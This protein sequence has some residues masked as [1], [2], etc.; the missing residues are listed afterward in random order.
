MAL[1]ILREELNFNELSRRRFLAEARVIG[2]LDHP[3]VIALHEVCVDDTGGL[4]YSMKR[5]DGTSWDKKIADMT[6]L[7][8]NPLDDI[9]AVGDIHAVIFNGKIASREAI[10]RELAELARKYEGF[11][12]DKLVT[13]GAR[14][15]IR[16][17]FGLV[18]TPPPGGW[19]S[20]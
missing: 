7:N 3:N 4:F 17:G 15:F 5:I 11:L 8:S 1:K 13:S 20:L 6:L 9:R 19:K 14:L 16:H 18:M 10:D 2:G 12:Y